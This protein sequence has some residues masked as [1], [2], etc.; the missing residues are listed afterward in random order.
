M[1][2]LD[3]CWSTSLFF[4]LVLLSGRIQSAHPSGRWTGCAPAVWGR[5]WKIHRRWSKHKYAEFVYSFFHDLTNLNASINCRFELPNENKKLTHFPD[6][7]VLGPPCI[8]HCFAE[9]F[10]VRSHRQ[11]HECSKCR[12]VTEATCVVSSRFMYKVALLSLWYSRRCFPI[13]AR[14][15]SSCR[16]SRKT[17]DRLLKRWITLEGLQQWPFQ[18]YQAIFFKVM[19]HQKQVYFPCY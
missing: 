14:I 11:Q 9:P 19:L 5:T 7:S 3:A 15:C 10:S 16:E 13:L 6:R 1:D 2:L 12:P 4:L 18:T 17:R 8:F